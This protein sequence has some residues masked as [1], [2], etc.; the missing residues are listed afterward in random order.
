MRV[1]GNSQKVVELFGLLDEFTMG[2]DI[3]EPRR[4][5]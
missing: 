5:R 1:E 4:Q 2:F 3:I